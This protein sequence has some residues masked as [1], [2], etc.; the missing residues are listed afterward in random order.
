MQDITSFQTGIHIAHSYASMYYMER[1]SGVEI[2]KLMNNLEAYG[3][4]TEEQ[5]NEIQ[6]TLNTERKETL[7][8]KYLNV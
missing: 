1:S 6:D 2:K 5:I 3:Y 8:S 4:L 7:L